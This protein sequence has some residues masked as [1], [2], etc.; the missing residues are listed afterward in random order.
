M[1][2]YCLIVREQNPLRAVTSAVLSLGTLGFG[3][4]DHAAACN[5]FARPVM[6]GRGPS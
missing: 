1:R 4:A 2:P 5:S 3:T 6:Q